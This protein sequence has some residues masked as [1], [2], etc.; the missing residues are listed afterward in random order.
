MDALPITEE[1]GVEHASLREGVMH[2]CGHDGHTAI[3]LGAAETLSQLDH[4]PNPVTFL[5]QPAEESGGGGMRMRDEG[6][7]DGSILGPAV[8]RIFGLHG[9]PQLPLG[10]VATR[11]GPIMASTDEFELTI[12]GQQAHA[13]QP[14]LGRDPIVAAA[15]CVTALQTIVSRT[16]DPLDAAVVTIGAIHAGT[17]SNII[18]EEVRMLGTIRALRSALRDELLEAVEKVAQR[19]AATFSCL[20]EFHPYEHY[21]VT[22]N[23]E[24]LAERF[25]ALAAATFGAERVERVRAPSMGAEDFAYYCQARPGCFCWL[26]LAPRDGGESAPLHSPRFDFNDEAIPMG[27]ATLCLAAL[28]EEACTAGC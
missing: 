4:R 8:D 7:L 21:P 25:L 10:V 15:H 13:A 14:H 17:A 9:W 24:A 11:P 23:D 27:V 20:A 6:A 2:A 19:T 3:L 28:D 16:V 12:R 5:F 26:G 22:V 1:T 18:P